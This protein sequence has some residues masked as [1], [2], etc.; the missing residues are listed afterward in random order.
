MDLQK[1][2]I[3]KQMIT[4]TKTYNFE[5]SDWSFLQTPYKILSML[6]QWIVNLILTIKRQ[7]KMRFRSQVLNIGLL[8]SIMTT[9]LFSPILAFA[10]QGTSCSSAYGQQCPSLQVSI[11]KKVKNPQTGEFVDSLSASGPNF[12]AGQEVNF[13]VE[14]KNSGTVD[15]DNAMVEDRLPDFVDFVAGPGSFNQST[16]MLSWTVE[17]LKPGDSKLFD[18]KVKI[19]S[20]KDLPDM[21]ITCLSNFSKVQKDN[22]SAQDTASFCIQTKILGGVTELPKTG[23]SDNMILFLSAVGLFATSAV[24]FKKFKTS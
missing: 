3:N 21:G 17:K 9:F 18:I 20:G 24:L 23:V 19:R 10:D 13:R 6:L 11:N 15:I 4:V 22:M 8:L 1:S 14:I 12:L 16:R 5:K 7:C 2:P